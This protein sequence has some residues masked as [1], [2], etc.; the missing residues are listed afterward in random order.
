MFVLL[1]SSLLLFT[2]CCSLFISRGRGVC[3]WHLHLFLCPPPPL[4][5][6]S[7]WSSWMP[8]IA[9]MVAV[10]A[11]VLYP[12]F[13]KSSSTWDPQRRRS[14]GRHTVSLYIWGGGGGVSAK[15]LMLLGFFL[16]FVFPLRRTLG[17]SL[18]LWWWRGSSFFLQQA[19]PSPLGGPRWSSPRETCSFPADAWMWRDRS[20]STPILT[21]QMSSS[22]S[23]GFYCLVI[24]AAR[25]C[26]V[27]KRIKQNR[28]LQE[29]ASP[30][31]SG[32][33]SEI[34]LWVYYFHLFGGTKAA[35]HVTVR[36]RKR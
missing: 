27:L 10:T 13:S 29:S 22:G 24:W 35:E 23:F 1:S 25:S 21:S 28:L 26:W 16:R 34:R 15:D 17:V 7:G 19:A 6:Q 32:S 11:A 3:F 2:S 9:V 36:R 5:P 30:P 4:P 12:S 8:V 14:C 20:I 18:I 33:R 31:G